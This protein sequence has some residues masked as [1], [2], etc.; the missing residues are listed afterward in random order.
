M[1]L[2]LALWRNDEISRYSVYESFLLLRSGPVK[3]FSHSTFVVMQ[4]SHSMI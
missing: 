4:N 3:M 2:K 1:R